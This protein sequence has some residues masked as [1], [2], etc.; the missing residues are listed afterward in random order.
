M[1]SPGNQHCANC[2]GTPSF[3]IRHNVAVFKLIRCI[4]ALLK[5]KQIIV[6]CLIFGFDKFQSTVL[7]FVTFLRHSNTNSIKTAPFMETQ[8][9]VHL[10]RREYKTEQHHKNINAGER[11]H[12]QTYYAVNHVN[13]CRK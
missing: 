6:Y 4:K 8:I 2:I 1:V 9:F 10:H 12:K 13:F 7:E 5:Y 11:T 3:P